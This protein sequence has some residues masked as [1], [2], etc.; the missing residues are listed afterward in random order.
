MGNCVK[1]RDVIIMSIGQKG[2]VRETTQTD[3]RENPRNSE[4]TLC[5]F[6]YRYL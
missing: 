3:V 6:A 2:N 5:R 1:W 4:K